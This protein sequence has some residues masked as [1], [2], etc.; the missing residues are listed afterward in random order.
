MKARLWRLTGSPPDES[1][2]WRTRCLC[3]AHKPVGQSINHSSLLQLLTLPSPLV[4]RRGDPNRHSLVIRHLCFVVA[5]PI[6]AALKRCE[7]ACALPPSQSYGLADIPSAFACHAVAERRRV[8]RISSFRP[9]PSPLRTADSTTFARCSVRCP[10]RSA[11]HKPVGQSINFH[12]ISN[13]FDKCAASAFTP[14]IS[15]A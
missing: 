13:R 2:P 9:S 12:G 5:E 11:V 1:V 15:V 6:C 8:I 7:D 4:K 14:K 10:Q 3:H